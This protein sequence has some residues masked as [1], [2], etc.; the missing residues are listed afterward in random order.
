VPAPRVIHAS[1]AL[2]HAHALGVPVA[3]LAREHV[4]PVSK[5]AM[6]RYL[7]SPRA[8]LER[9]E[10]SGPRRRGAHARRAGPQDQDAPVDREVIE[11]R[12]PQGQDDRDADLD[13]RP[14]ASQRVISDDRRRQVHALRAAGWSQMR[15]SEHVDVSLR[16]VAR[17]LSEPK[18]TPS[19]EE[20]RPT[21]DAAP[22][23]E[24]DDT[25]P[26][27]E[28]PDTFSIPSYT[29]DGQD[30][31]RVLAVSTKTF[32]AAARWHPRTDVDASLRVIWLVK[33]DEIRPFHLGGGD[34]PERWITP[35]GTGFPR[36]RKLVFKL[37]NVVQLKRLIH[38]ALYD[39]VTREDTTMPGDDGSG[40]K[41]LPAIIIESPYA[42]QSH[43]P[44]SQQGVT[45]PRDPFEGMY[46]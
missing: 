12:A 45:G 13:G 44:W 38:I 32:L 25:P 16:S 19:N 28:A 7:L 21:L 9:A 8:Q 46:G 33:Q 4:P 31:G 29:V 30:V 20:H 15:I 6:R 3:K 27:R 11:V 26:Q 24:P 22:E 17:I 34:R 1:P 37:D 42:S 35:P 43:L 41:V 39:A 36:E 23:P 10:L 40:G 14:E 5:Q 18:P 2:F